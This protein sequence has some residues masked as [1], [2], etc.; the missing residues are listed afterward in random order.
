MWI[1]RAS[2]FKKEKCQ[3]I[4]TH[5]APNNGHFFSIS[6]RSIDCCS[7]WLFS[8][9]KR[10]RQS[11]R[12]TQTR[13]DKEKQIVE[14]HSNLLQKITFW[15][16]ILFEEKRSRRR[17]MKLTLFCAFYCTQTLQ[18]NIGMPTEWF[19]IFFA[20]CDGIFICFWCFFLRYNQL[21][22]WHARNESHSLKFSCHVVSALIVNVHVSLHTMIYCTHKRHTASSIQLQG[23]KEKIIYLFI[24]SRRSTDVHFAKSVLTFSWSTIELMGGRLQEQDLSL[25]VD[26]QN[27]R[28]QSYRM[29]QISAFQFPQRHIW[30]HRQ[31]PRRNHYLLCEHIEASLELFASVFSSAGDFSVRIPS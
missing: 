29:I 19:A 4:L 14:N 21:L 5:R 23:K 3:N 2:Y 10:R 1:Y 30:R 8:S 15:R 12:C 27:Y 11:T 31:S 7:L 25:S 18:T 13:E 9:Q 16:S 24:K 26:S 28:N 20:C 17:L 6:N 22:Y